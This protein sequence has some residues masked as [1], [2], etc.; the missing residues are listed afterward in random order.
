MATGEITRRRKQ[1]LRTVERRYRAVK[2][3]L[4]GLG[5]V[6][7]GSVTE[8]WMECGKA[9]CPCHVDDE[10]RH[11]PYLQWSWKSEGRT[12]SVYLDED[13]AAICRQWIAN[14]R[15]LEEIVRQLRAVS[16]RAARVHE[17]ARD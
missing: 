10:A 13:E 17:I 11:G 2:A 8:R 4:A 6:L 3:R 1:A 7:Q 15:R 16:L 5:F 9:A 12:R 14:N